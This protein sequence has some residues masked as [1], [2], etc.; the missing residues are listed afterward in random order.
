ATLSRSSTWRYAAC[1]LAT[2]TAIA[3][4]RC[5]QGFG[6]L[7]RE[8]RYSAF[9]DLGALDPASTDEVAGVLV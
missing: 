4:P 2:A 3:L 7:P 8:F 6:S 5:H 1:C 9:N